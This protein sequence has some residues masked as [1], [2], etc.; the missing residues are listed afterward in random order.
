[1]RPGL[2]LVNLGSPASP[3]PADVKHYLKSFL[4]DPSIIK[5]PSILWQ[6]LLRGV[7]L[8]LQ[9]GRSATIYRDSWTT[10]GSPL[11]VRSQQ[12]QALVQ[13]NLPNWDVRLAMTYGKPAI[14]ATLTAMAAAG[15]EQVIVLPLFPQYTPSTHQSI[16]NQ[17]E[18]TA[19][20]IT[21]IKHFYDEADYVQLLAD[22]VQA[23]YQRHHYDRVIFSYQSIPSTLVRHGDPYQQECLATTQAVLD[24]LPALPKDRVITAFQ[25]KF[26]P[27]PWLK[28]Y[29]KNELRSLAEKGHRDVLIVTP[30]FVVDCLETL[31]ANH[32]QR[33]RATGGQRLDIVPPM[34]DSP[35]FSQFLANLATRWWDAQVH[36]K[37]N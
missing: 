31:E 23:S 36:A 28:P 6:P 2:L 25:S 13:D 4:S 10:A 7:I 3:Q 18:A 24:R 8:P 33:F 5:L 35:Q 1:M 20:P 12:I 26:G 16:L 21:F 29:L 14:N 22:Q 34:N 17:A 30:S 15:C 9:A 27:L 32:G 19:V 11:I 37:E